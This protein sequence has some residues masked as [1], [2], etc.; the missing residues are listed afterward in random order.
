MSFL[1]P[2]T[3]GWSL[4]SKLIKKV[5]LNLFLMKNKFFGFIDFK[6]ENVPLKFLKKI[7]SILTRS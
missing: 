6:K 2:G 7:G 4:G 1:P 5:I 3:T